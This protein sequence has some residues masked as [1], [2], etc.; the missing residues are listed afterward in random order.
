M[1]DD[2]PGP[3]PDSDNPP[4][5]PGY[6][7][8]YAKPPK[9]TRFKPGQSG[10]PKGRPKGTGSLAQSLRKALFGRISVTENGRVKS[11]P[12]LDAIMKA[13]RLKALKGDVRAAALLIS[14]T[15]VHKVAAEPEPD[16]EIQIQF[17]KPDQDW[18]ER[19]ERGNEV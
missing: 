13:M 16:R 2:Q 19:M 14:L 11:M 8:G 7:V 5:R 9:A 18:I 15:E 4:D 10:N 17:I 6:D 12:A 3:E 1:A